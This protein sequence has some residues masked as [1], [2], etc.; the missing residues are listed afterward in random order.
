MPV[1][2]TVKSGGGGGG[3]EALLRELRGK[4][5]SEPFRATELAALRVD[6]IEYADTE[7]QLLAASS[8]RPISARVWRRAISFSAESQLVCG[9]D[10]YS[11][12]SCTSMSGP[13]KRLATDSVGEGGRRLP[14]LA[15]KDDAADAVLAAGEGGRCD[16]ARPFLAALISSNRLRLLS[17]ALE[18]Q[19]S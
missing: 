17:C 1:P 16:S 14:P 18:G 9:A 10:T 7:L 4:F 3:S 19:S 2:P 6:A 15:T 11:M 8:A 12:A 5:A 13:S